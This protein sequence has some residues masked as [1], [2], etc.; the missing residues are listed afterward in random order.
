METL[1][2]EAM[3]DSRNK[4]ANAAQFFVLPFTEYELFSCYIVNMLQAYVGIHT[5]GMLP[6]TLSHFSSCAVVG[7]HS[8]AEFT[9]GVLE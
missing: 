7:F 2:P 9:S 5:D 3:G 8:S 4:T 6:F 1:T